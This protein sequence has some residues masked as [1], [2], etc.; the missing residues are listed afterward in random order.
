MDKPLSRSEPLFVTGH[1]GLVGSAIVRR[2][3]GAG[4]TRLLTA[5]RSELDLRDPAAVER[6][7]L[8]QR[9]R[10]VIH[11]AGTVGGIQANSARPV[12]FLHDNVMM[13]ATVLKAAYQSGVEK[14][15][16][17][18]SSCV[19]PRQCPQPIK[20]EYLLTGPLEP[21][22]EPYAI[23]KIAGIKACQAYR[24]QY[25]ARFISAMP[26]NIYGPG[27]SFDP[28]NSHVLAA[29]ICKFDDAKRRG[30]HVVTL[31]GTGTPRRELLH[32]D[33]AADACLFLLENYDDALP[34]NV[35]TGDDLPIADLAERVREIVYP[36]AEIQFDTTRPDGTPRKVLDV[37][38]LRALGW[39]HRV[40]LPEGIRATYD[41]YC[42]KKLDREGSEG[43]GE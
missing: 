22:N 39:R 11:A 12:D 4:F 17:L 21:T 40:E 19:Y 9:P 1:R 14:L 33:D 25:G 38:R 16:Y 36:E 26:S 41:W 7:F 30:R 10:Y 15:L 3:A 35:G 37:S 43:E 29:M 28:E 34:I 27:D 23:A 6:W 8:R 31:W 2:L 18:G 13:Q 42:Q 32:V 24:A 5:P 20:E